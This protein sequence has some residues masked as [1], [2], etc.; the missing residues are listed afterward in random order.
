[1]KNKIGNKEDGFTL[2]ELLTVVAIIAILAAIAVPRLR[3][4]RARSVRISMISDAKNVSTALEAYFSDND[5]YSGADG[6]TAT[7][8]NQFAAG[9]ALAGL[10][11]S[12]GNT[13]SIGATATS[14]TVTITNPAGDGGEYT[15]PL[16]VFGYS[17]CLWASG[18][19][20]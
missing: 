8:P 20:C 6:N 17:D 11:V 18:Q 1:M 10:K 7:G 13:V 5:S 4:Y 16:D 2:L 9:A 12:K 3:G 14:F 15:G 19:D